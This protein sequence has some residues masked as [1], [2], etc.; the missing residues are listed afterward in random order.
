MTNKI[1]IAFTA[2]LVSLSSFSQT[3]TQIVAKHIEAIGGKEN[4]SKVKSLRLESSMKMQGTEIK[5]ITTQ[6]DK[7]A[8]RLDI[9]VM[10][11]NGYQ[12]VTTTEGWSFMPFQGQTKPEPM[13]VDDVKMSQDQLEIQSDF[14]TY[15]EKEK[16]LEDLGTEE[17]DGVECFKLKLTDKDGIET[18]YFID[19]SNYFLI[20]ETSKIK[21][22]GQEMENVVT[23]NN[24]ELTNEGILLPKNIVSLQGAMEITKTEVNPVIDEAIFIVKK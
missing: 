1:I 19:Q 20:K 5:I 23:Y 18:S 16:K 3:A 10:G 12:V 2:V 21:A 11:M 7:K 6:I 24:Y 22:N 15:I 13:T 4:W 8:L 14:I 17:V 9:S